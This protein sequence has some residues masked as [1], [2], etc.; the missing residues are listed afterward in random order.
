MTDPLGNSEFCFPRISM[1]PSTSSRE[2]LRFSG[3]K[4]HCS[5]R[6]K[7]LSVK[8]LIR[9]LHQII[10]V[11]LEF[12]DELIPKETDNLILMLSSIS[13]GSLTLDAAWNIC[14]SP[15]D[16][17]TKAFINRVKFLAF[18]KLKSLFSFS[19]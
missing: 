14:H 10:L 8:Y 19:S 12:E 2:T 6:D 4:I 15:R 13:V 9:K 17:M 18:H 3:N 16:L 11:E 7:S 5:P 1:F